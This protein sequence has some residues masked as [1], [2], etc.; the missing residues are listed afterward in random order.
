MPIPDIRLVYSSPWRDGSL[1]NPPILAPR[2]RTATD[3]VLPP[4]CGNLECRPPKTPVR[5]IGL[6]AMHNDLN[7][8]GSI[9][10]QGALGAP[11]I[12]PAIEIAGFLAEVL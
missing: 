12:P 7:A 3:P 8:S 2:W 5:T 6:G 4:L 1:A 9:L 11:A 10:P